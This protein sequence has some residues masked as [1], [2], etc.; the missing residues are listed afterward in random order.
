MDGTWKLDGSTLTVSA[1]GSE[2]VAT[3][4]GDKIM[5]EGQPFEKVQ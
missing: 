1:G 2:Y 3:I 5:Y 4:E